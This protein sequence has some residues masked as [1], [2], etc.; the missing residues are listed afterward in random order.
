MFDSVDLSIDLSFADNFDRHL[1][2]SVRQTMDRQL[3]Q[4][5]AE[6]RTTSPKGVSQPDSLRSGWQHAMLSDT[7]ALLTN[8]TPAAFNRL[9][10]R[11]PGQE[12]PSAP[13]TPLARWAE[14]KGL[15]PRAV[16]RKIAREGTER[17]KSGENV[18][19]VDRETGQPISGGRLDQFIQ[20]LGTALGRLD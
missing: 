9:V 4:L 10:G 12:P 13:G 7:S 6:L 20:E 18:L 2:Q 5:V 14:S 15:K 19:G 16:A 17:W 11:P 8:D 1:Q 3:G